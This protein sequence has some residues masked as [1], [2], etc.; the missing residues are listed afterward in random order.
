M[1]TTKKL[2]KSLKQN[3]GNCTNYRI[4]KI[5]DCSPRAVSNWD[6]G[7]ATMDD[8]YARK[9]ANLLGLDEDYVVACITAER[10]KN[11]SNYDLWK[12]ICHRLGAVAALLFVSVSVLPPL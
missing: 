2:L 9:A 12:H 10:N 5:L 7:R 8:T 3:N 4:H 1:W 11:T 6:N